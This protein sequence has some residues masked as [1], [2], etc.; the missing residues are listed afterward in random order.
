MK[1]NNGWMVSRFVIGNFNHAHT[2]IHWKHVH[3]LKKILKLFYILKEFSKNKT[4]TN[5][6]ITSTFN[7]FRIKVTARIEGHSKFLFQFNIFLHI[8]Y[9]YNIYTLE[10]YKY[11]HMC[12]YYGLKWVK[13]KTIAVL[14][15]KTNIH[16]ENLP[17]T[18]AAISSSYI[19]LALLC[20]AFAKIY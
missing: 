11:S 2:F 4:K 1:E 15:S 18:I 9:I 7:R 8:M 6:E 17:I 5:S 12:I 19:W 10:M 20:L 14:F 3:F 13:F 16:L